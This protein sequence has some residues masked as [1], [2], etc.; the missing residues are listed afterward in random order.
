MGEDKPNFNTHHPELRK[1]EVFL[2]N[3]TKSDFSHCT[4]VTKRLGEQAYSNIGVR[5]RSYY[6]PD[7][8]P[9]VFPLFI[10]TWEKRMKEKGL[11]VVTDEKEEE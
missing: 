1:N 6:E 4:F 9:P 10:E 3:A 7:L 8:P 5:L 11:R 2:M